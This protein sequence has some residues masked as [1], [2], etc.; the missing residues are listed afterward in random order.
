MVNLQQSPRH[1]GSFSSTTVEP[2][3]S[4]LHIP[5]RFFLS[6]GCWDVNPPIKLEYIPGSPKDSEYIIQI[7]RKSPLVF[8]LFS[9]ARVIIYFNP[10]RPTPTPTEGSKIFFEASQLHATGI[11]AAQWRAGW[12]TSIDL[13]FEIKVRKAI[14]NFAAALIVYCAAD[15]IDGLIFRQF[16]HIPAINVIVTIVVLSLH[17]PLR[18]KLFR[19]YAHLEEDPYLG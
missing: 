9:V 11:I 13:V 18:K 7:R 2:I 6:H 15:I 10:E 5:V 8:R 17:R 4:Y 14:S 3:P 19:S 16:K 12:I 1:S